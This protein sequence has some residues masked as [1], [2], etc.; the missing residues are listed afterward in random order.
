[1]IGSEADFLSCVFPSL[2]AAMPYISVNDLA[3]VASNQPWK[4]IPQDDGYDYFLMGRR[5]GINLDDGDEPQS[6]CDVN[7][8]VRA[9]EF[10][11][12]SDERTK[13]GVEALPPAAGTDVARRLGV[14]KYSLIRDPSKR[15]RVGMIAQDVRAALPGAVREAEDGCLSIDVNQIIGVLLATVKHLDAR[16]LELERR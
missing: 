13:R 2:D 16:I 11:V 6:E 12:V 15:L 9:I 3:D 7:G 8:K 5:L 1:M 14:Y 10:D 4:K